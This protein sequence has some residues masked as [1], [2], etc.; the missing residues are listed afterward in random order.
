MSK[1]EDD[2]R[3]KRKKRKSKRKRK[4]GNV[5]RFIVLF[6]IIGTF[7]SST[8]LK[9]KLM[10]ILDKSQRTI[11]VVDEKSIPWPMEGEIKIVSDNIIEYRDK[12]LTCYD[13]EGNT[14]W[15]KSI[16]LEKPLVYIGN[17]MIYL[18]NRTSGE[19]TAI[20]YNGQI[21]WKYNLSQTITYIFEQKD[22]V[23]VLTNQND[24]SERVSILDNKGKLLVDEVMNTGRLIY[25]N[26]SE[27]KKNFVIVTLDV[28]NNAFESKLMLFSKNGNLLWERSFEN[29]IVKYVEFVDNELFV[30][31]DDKMSM[32][33]EDGKLLW[34]R[35]IVGEIRD[36]AVG[37]DKKSILLLSN[38]GNDFLET[39]LANGRTKEKIEV[40]GNHYEIYIENK[41]IFLVGYNEILGIRE[42]YE[43]LKYTTRGDIKEFGIIDDKIVFFTF[44]EMKIGEIVRNEKNKGR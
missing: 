18:G 39:I 36:V 12:E 14:L 1:I 3:K 15:N 22:E 8:T 40:Q 4:K 7:L 26:I 41:N 38:N 16:L 44:D 43:F 32:I 33:D 13:N 20:D 28:L 25:G 19:I 21:V 34:S 31:S 17:Q 30:L 9:E 37:N 2:V 29:Q 10:E 24:N 35:D 5:G 6:I 11:N 42:T 23:F 27:N